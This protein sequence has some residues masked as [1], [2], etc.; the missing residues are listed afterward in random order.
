M[1]S[2]LMIHIVTDVGSVEMLVNMVTLTR[3]PTLAS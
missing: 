1:T 2:I 3:L